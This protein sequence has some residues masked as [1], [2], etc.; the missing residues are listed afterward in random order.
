MD[1]E[2][3][4]RSAPAVVVGCVGS[5]LLVA[6]AVLGSLQILVLNPLAAVPGRPLPDIYR[7]AAAANE[8]FAVGWV[9]AFALMGAALSVGSLAFAL[10]GGAT[11]RGTAVFALLALMLG[12]PAYFVASFSIGMAIADAF[13]T[14]GGDHSSWS[15][16]LFG[17]SGC[18]LLALAVL[19]VEAAVRPAVRG[20][21]ARRARVGEPSIR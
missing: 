13:G 19:A 12:T 7:D 18:A 10:R 11:W 8:P 9:V 6:F 4:P 1:S 15:S 21:A 3:S 20:A 5:V 2:K 16:V 14:S 17:A